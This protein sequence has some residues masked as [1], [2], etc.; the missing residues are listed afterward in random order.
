MTDQQKVILLEKLSSAREQVNKLKE[1]TDKLPAC[2]E[3][4]FLLQDI[5]K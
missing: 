1:L 2:D 5:K 3:K 4:T